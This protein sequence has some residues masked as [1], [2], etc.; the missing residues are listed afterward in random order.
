MSKIKLLIA[1]K[2]F[3]NQR[4]Y[5]FWIA[6]AL[7]NPVMSDALKVALSSIAHNTDDMLNFIIQTSKIILKP[8]YL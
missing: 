4:N 1:S 8:N 6:A 2:G 3:V 5:Y 7:K